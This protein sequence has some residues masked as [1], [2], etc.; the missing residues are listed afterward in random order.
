VVAER[1]QVI[2]LV[3][4]AIAPYNRGGKE[5]RTQQLAPRLAARADV[6]VY[7]MNWWQGPPTRRDG[8]VTYH[9]V[10]PYVP[11]Y[12]GRRRSIRQAL[13]FA[14]FCLRL[15][16]VR[17]DV[18]EADS[19]P[20]IQ[21]LPLKFVTVVRR[22]RLFVTWH[23]CWG[24]DYWRAYLGRAGVFGWFFES[25]ALRIADG[26]IAA[27]PQTGE[28]LVALNRSRVPVIIAPNGIDVSRIDEI[29][30]SA[31]G[32][33]LVTVGRLLPHKRID[34]LVE[35]VAILKARGRPLMTEVVGVGPE[36]E[37]LKALAARRGVSDLVQFR[38]DVREQDD[39]Y[40]LI[41]SA[42]VGVFPSEREG[43]GIAVLEALACGISVVATSAPDNLAR[44]LVERSANGIVCEPSAGSI[45]D[46]IA[47]IL[48][49]PGPSDQD[50]SDWIRDYD[51]DAISKTVAEALA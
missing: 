47:K 5:Q 26:V 31:D 29:E 25:L 37:P 44:F 10:C 13:T 46:A 35:A 21:L 36:L 48:D 51:W 50:D 9:A 39:L 30:A 6:H 40:R 22:R 49:E 38:E 18:L 45:A 28:R 24:P 34:L 43:F 42:R 23:E 12:S 11:L 3:T 15:L 41:K 14:V 27:S 2:A 4:D 17:F 20:Y 8:E 19:M 32:A 1:R 16:F 33:D 7:T